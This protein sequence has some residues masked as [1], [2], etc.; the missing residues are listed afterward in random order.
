MQ[1]KCVHLCGLARDWLSSDKALEWWTVH[2]VFFVWNSTDEGSQESFWCYYT[3]WALWW[4]V[5][6]PWAPPYSLSSRQRQ[7]GS[8]LCV[9]SQKLSAQRA[10]RWRIILALRQSLSVT[11]KD[12]LQLQSYQKSRGTHWHSRT[13]AGCLESGQISLNGIPKKHFF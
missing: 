11:L 9:D 1:S 13:L 7:Y 3:K 10:A 6:I 2:R 5:H 8:Y 12:L 4:T